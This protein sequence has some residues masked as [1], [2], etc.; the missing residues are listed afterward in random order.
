MTSSG[1]QIWS[2][3]V[4]EQ[5]CVGS[6]LCAGIAPHRFTLVDGLARPTTRSIRA[7]ETVIDAAESC[8]MEAIVVHDGNGTLLAPQA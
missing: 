7:D 4:D 1:E 8:P 5:Q 3:S 6:G 2:V